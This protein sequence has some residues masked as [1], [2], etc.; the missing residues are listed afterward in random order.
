MALEIYWGLLYYFVEEE[1]PSKSPLVGQ[2]LMR[3]FLKALPSGEGWMGLMR[4]TILATIQ[5]L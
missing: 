1:A 5:K 3:V 4:N 2:T